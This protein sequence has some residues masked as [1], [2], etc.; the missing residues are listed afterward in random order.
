MSGEDRLIACTLDARAMLSR[1]AWIERVAAQGLVSYRLQGRSLRLTYQ[2][3]AA[4]EI[5]SIVALERECCGFLDFSLET[6]PD[7]VVLT[8]TAPPS[9]DV[10]AAWLFDPILPER[11]TGAQSSASCR[12]CVASDG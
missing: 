7:E 9:V 2:P 12:C 11:A 1:R 5:S 6:T 3:Q 8:I 4:A 10:D